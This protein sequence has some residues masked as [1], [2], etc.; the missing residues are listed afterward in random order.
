[1]KIYVHIYGSSLKLGRSWFEG[2][3][4][5]AGPSVR[6]YGKYLCCFSSQYD[7]TVTQS[8]RRW[9]KRPKASDIKQWYISWVFWTWFILTG[10]RTNNPSSPTETCVQL[11]KRG[12]CEKRTWMNWTEKC[13]RW[14][15]VSLSKCLWLIKVW[16]LLAKRQKYEREIEMQLLF[17]G[18]GQHFRQVNLMCRG[19]RSMIIDYTNART[20]SH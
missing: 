12:V 15:S 14:C 2:T 20:T 8:N 9:W 19:L 1:M 10:N 18:W 3:S 7:V 4:F 5:S 16:L 17:R 13:W 11:Y 6:V